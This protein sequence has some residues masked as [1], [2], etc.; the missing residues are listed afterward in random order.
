MGV[1]GLGF[2]LQEDEYIVSSRA[3]LFQYI[4][5]ST[6][7]ASQVIWI[8]S[9]LQTSQYPVIEEASKETLNRLP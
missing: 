4:T 5:L 9:S 3:S 1:F 7:T 2:K 8:S 6:S